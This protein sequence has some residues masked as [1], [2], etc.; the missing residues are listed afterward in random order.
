MAAGGG[1]H[2]ALECDWAHH[3]LIGG[4]G[5]LAGGS[6][7]EQ[8]RRGRGGAPAAARVSEKLEA[9]KINARPW[10]LEGDLGKG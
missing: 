6:S 3:A 5:G 1:K 9:G 4:G 10:E 8:R 7:G 2:L